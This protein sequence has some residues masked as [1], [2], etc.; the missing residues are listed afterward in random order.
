MSII[1]ILL[2]TFLK[3]PKTTPG[4]PIKTCAGNSTKIREKCQKSKDPEIDGGCFLHPFFVAFQ[5]NGLHWGDSKTPKVV[6]FFY[7]NS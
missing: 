6:S 3:R 7:E 2:P 4:S 1:H 5:I